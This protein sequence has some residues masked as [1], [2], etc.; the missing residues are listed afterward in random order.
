MAALIRPITQGFVPQKEKK[1]I[2]SAD[3][4]LK[5]IFVKG[6]FFGWSRPD[7]CPRCNHW[8]VWGHGF[9]RSLFEGFDV[10]LYLKRYRCPCCGCI[11][12]LRPS[13]H[14]NRFQT[15]KT[16]IRSALNQRIAHGK[17]PPSDHPGRLRH[18]LRNLKRQTQAHLT[19]RFRGGLMAAFD[20][21]VGMGIVPVSRS[22]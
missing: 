17:W 3:V 22:I 9:R 18:W 6:R 14:F 21:L 4:L 16:A 7:S 5:N 12:V 11:I 8:K 10:P 15:S 2:L 1:M 20:R 13:S 19:L